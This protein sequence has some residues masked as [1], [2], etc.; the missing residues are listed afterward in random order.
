MI[1]TMNWLIRQLTQSPQPPKSDYSQYMIGEVLNLSRSEITDNNLDSVISY[2]NENNIKK[3]SL[4]ACEISN[5]GLE[6][7]AELNLKN[8]WLDGV[9]V[10]E[11][12]A[13]ILSKMPLSLLSLNDCQLTDAALKHITKI[14]NLKWLFL[15]GN[16]LTISGCVHLRNLTR[17]RSLGLG[18]NANLGNEIV[19]ILKDLIN[20]EEL[21]LLECG[22]TPPGHL[23]HLKTLVNLR[24]LTV[25]IGKV[26]PVDPLNPITA[27]PLSL[28]G[29]ENLKK[30][31]H[32]KIQC[33]VG[34]TPD[35]VKILSGLP[36]QNL[37]VTGCKI[38]N[39]GFKLLFS[40]PK[41][42][43][44]YLNRNPAITSNE[45]ID[46]LSNNYSLVTLQPD[47]LH[48]YQLSEANYLK[49]QKIVQ[50]NAKIDTHK[51]Q[52][53][54]ENH[55]IMTV[56]VLAQGVRQKEI[57]WL[58]AAMLASILQIAFPACSRHFD[59]LEMMVKCV[60]RNLKEKT[61][62]NTRFEPKQA[63]KN[64]HPGEVKQIF[65]SGLGSSARLF[66]EQADKPNIRMSLAPAIFK[67]QETYAPLSTNL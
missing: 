65:R 38:N 4:G 55:L 43:Y 8:L 19:V 1:T 27:P 31:Q 52:F 29:F 2:I 56:I 15:N 67:E 24:S 7:L 49:A 12:G 47:F 42:E 28:S 22:L 25:T 18:F 14:R 50:D 53:I 51:E 34:L 64:E 20:L 33:Q 44:L 10:D 54:L 36:I 63:V 45:V 58:P 57:L 32:L 3:L 60:F 21:N 16:Q 17:L 66:K 41:L 30:L 23:G 61:N 62:W 48:P 9:R 59:E 5:T 13:E 35:S 6:R 40:L 46:V 11:E 39:E 26:G 37:D